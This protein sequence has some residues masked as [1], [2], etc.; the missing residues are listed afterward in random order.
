MRKE[1]DELEILERARVLMM[2]L[3]H[4]HAKKHR[5]AKI[6]KCIEELKRQRDIT[7]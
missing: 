7:K 1:L 4:L 3:P 5:L 2:A 6:D